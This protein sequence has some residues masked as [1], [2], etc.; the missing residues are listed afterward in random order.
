MIKFNRNDLK[1]YIELNTDLRK[2]SKKQY[3][4]KE[5]KMS[6]NIEILILLQQK[7]EG[8]I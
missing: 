4:E 2:E 3:F 5:W 1:P 6:E 7:E 8:T